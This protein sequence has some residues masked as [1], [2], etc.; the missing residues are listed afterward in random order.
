MTLVVLAYRAVLPAD[1][2]V[3]FGILYNG[4]AG[5]EHVIVR[6]ERMDNRS[7]YLGFLGFAKKQSG[8]LTF[9][10]LFWCPFP[11]LPHRNRTN[12]DSRFSV[13]VVTLPLVPYHSLFKP[14]CLHPSTDKEKGI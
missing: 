14:P 8:L 4:F 3:L 10:L 1:L 9:I 6:C 2:P 12:P 13:W 11:V 5:A 7:F